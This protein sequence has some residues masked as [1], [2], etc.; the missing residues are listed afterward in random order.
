MS[1]S[2]GLQQFLL[3]KMRDATFSSSSILRLA[4]LCNFLTDPD[5]YHIEIIVTAN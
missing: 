1:M 2:H 3:C 4:L 5:F